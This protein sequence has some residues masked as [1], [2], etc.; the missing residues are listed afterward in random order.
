MKFDFYGFDAYGTLFDIHSAVARHRE[1]VGPMADR[2]SEVW[3]NKQL[4]Y[5]WTRNS[6]GQYR[7]FWLLTEQALDFALAAVPGA[8]VDAKKQLLGAYETLD[9]YDDVAGVLRKLQGNGAKTAILSNGSPAMLESAVNHAGIADCLDEVISVDPIKTYKATQTV[10]ALIANS[11]GA[12]P[13]EISFQSSNRW[14]IAGAKTFGF[15]C[16][17]INRTGQPDEYLDLSPDEVHADL[18]GIVD[19]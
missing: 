14:D 2:V 17:W 4:E 16:Q 8:N 5:S 18:S 19:S 15:Y 11:F 12:R 13:E 3:R 1:L 10:Y 7:E 9:C 6:M